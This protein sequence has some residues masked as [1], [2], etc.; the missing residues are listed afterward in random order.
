MIF[1]ET[2]SKEINTDRDSAWWNND[3]EDVQRRR[4]LFWELFAFERLQ[5]SLMRPIGVMLCLTIV[6]LGTLP[7][8]A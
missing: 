8:S 7:V 2:Y 5:A 4:D 6:H 1:L 3:T